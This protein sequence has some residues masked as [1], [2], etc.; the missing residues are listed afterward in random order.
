MVGLLGGE[1]C[2]PRFLVWVTGIAV[3]YWLGYWALV[4]FVVLDGLDFEVVHDGYGGAR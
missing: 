3:R 1:V 4:K 2:F